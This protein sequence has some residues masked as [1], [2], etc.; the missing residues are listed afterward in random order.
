MSHIRAFIAI[1]LSPEIKQ[2]IQVVTNSLFMKLKGYPVKSVLSAHIHLTL[3][4]LGDILQ[5][6]LPK[7]ELELSRVAA[8]YSPFD[9]FIK[10]IGVF[11]NYN[12]PRV[13]WI[14]FYGG[15]DGGKQILHGL[16]G[17]IQQTVERFGFDVDQREYNPHLTIG[18]INQ[19]NAQMDLLQLGEVVKSEK[20]GELGLLHVNQFHLIRSE[21]RPSGPIYTRLA[22]YSLKNQAKLDEDKK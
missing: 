8:E 22:T 3:L 11:P 9:L 18:R 21:L 10:G 2:S 5:S 16:Q 20:V 15:P 6:D 1:E 14:G 13:I 4:F 7:I 19:N 12:K 17:K